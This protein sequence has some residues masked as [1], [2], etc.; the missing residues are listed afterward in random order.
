MRLLWRRCMLRAWTPH[1]GGLTTRCTPACT[2]TARPSAACCATPPA[3]SH[4]HTQKR[5]RTFHFDIVLRAVV[6]TTRCNRQGIARGDSRATMSSAVKPKRRGSGNGKM[7]KKD[8]ELYRHGHTTMNS[9]RLQLQLYPHSLSL[10][11]PPVP[12]LSFPFLPFPSLSFPF[13]PLM[14]TCCK[15]QPVLSLWAPFEFS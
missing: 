14:Q 8:G 11:L 2:C 10:L 9:G 7:Q 3:S 6:T 12:S 13:L 4:V 1:S 5:Y 15:P